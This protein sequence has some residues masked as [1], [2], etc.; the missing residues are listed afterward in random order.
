[1]WERG[2]EWVCGMSFHA[3]EWGTCVCVVHSSSHCPLPLPPPHTHTW[4]FYPD[5]DGGVVLEAVV[6]ATDSIWETDRLTLL[7][8]L[9]ELDLRGNTSLTT[10]SH[11]TMSHLHMVI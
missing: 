3:H 10:P 5:A 2:K 11:F 8:Q 6:I 9:L 7:L 1:M 4:I